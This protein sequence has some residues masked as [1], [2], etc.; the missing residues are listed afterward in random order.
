MSE[1]EA[2]STAVAVPEPRPQ[3][4]A[5]GKALA[6]IPR[7]LDELQRLA[8]L[9][10]ASGLMPSSIK[11]KEGV[12]I[13]VMAGLEVGLSPMQSVQNI[14]VIN[15]RPCMWGDSVL[16]LVQASGLLADYAETPIKDGSGAVVG[17]R[18]WAVRKGQ[19][20]PIEN[21]F[22]LDDAKRA[23]LASKPGPW[24]EYTQR[25]LKMRARGFTLRDGFAD[26]LRG[27]RVREEVEDYIDVS[28][29]PEMPSVPTLPP[30]PKAAVTEADVREVEEQADSPART[31]EDEIREVGECIG[32]KPPEIAAL[33]KQHA[34]AG[35]L[36]GLRD[37]FR[38]S[39]RAQG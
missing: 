21:T 13:A 33:L 28:P 31:I 37:E 5:G 34:K 4:T 22:T 17:Y 6:L 3:I 10:F 25:M 11:T 39:Y 32:K 15:G 12:A 36:E 38:A 1:N 7:T 2:K 35:T 19:S 27:M 20:Q 29:V 18:A 23:K 30:M 24:S 26:V 14:A 8:A 16:A 9:M